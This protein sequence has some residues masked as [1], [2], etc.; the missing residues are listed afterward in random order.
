MHTTMANENYE[1]DWKRFLKCKEC[2]EF[3]E[4]NEQNWYKHHQW[5]MWVL[6]RCKECIKKWRSSERELIMARKRDSDRW[7]NNP[8]RHEYMSKA[9]IIR[10]KVKWYW[11]IHQ[12]VSKIIKKLWIDRPSKCT[13][14]W[15]ENKIYAHHPDYNKPYEV[16]FVCQ[17]CH[18]KIH[19]WK[20]KCPT[21]LKLLP[22]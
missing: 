10:R 4:L 5:F 21:P 3:K 11:K 13:I 17:P 14:C 7:H 19:S 18:S 20:I 1:K 16:V 15:C 9:N 2:W 12:R 6:W 8:K 22:F